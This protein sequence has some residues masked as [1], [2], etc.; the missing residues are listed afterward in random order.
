MDGGECPSDGSQRGAS[1]IFVLDGQSR[2]AV[3]VVPEQGANAMIS[4]TSTVAGVSAAIG[5]LCFLIQ[6][7]GAK[8]RAEKDPVLNLIEPKTIFVSSAGYT[9]DLVA[10]ANLALGTAFS[11]EEGLEAADALCQSLADGPDSIVPE[12]KYGALLSAGDVNAFSRIAPSIGPYIRPDGAPVAPNWVSLF[13][14][15]VDPA[16]FTYLINI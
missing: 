10:E 11:N 2:Q 9:G 14:P 3:A 8:D 15:L 16:T 4:K 13:A 5:I 7:V 1:E 12:G 6:P